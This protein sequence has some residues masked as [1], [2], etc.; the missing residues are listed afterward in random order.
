MSKLNI[1]EHD[2]LASECPICEECKECKSDKLLDLFVKAARKQ[3]D[4]RSKG[5]QHAPFCNYQRDDMSYCNCG[6]TDLQEALRE[7]ER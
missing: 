2:Q 3:K 1:C 5:L 7:Y 6:I 4:W